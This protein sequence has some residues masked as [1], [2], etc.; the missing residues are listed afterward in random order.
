MIDIVVVLDKSGSMYTPRDDTIGSFNE[1]LETQ[2]QDPDD[3]RMSL[4]MFNDRYIPIYSQKEL[5]DVEELDRFGYA[6]SGSTALLDAVGETITK[7]QDDFNENTIFVIITDGQE[8]SSKEYSVEAVRALVEDSEAKGWE[9]HFLGVGLDDFSDA[10]SI[11]TRST[12]SFDH[13][14]SGVSHMYAATGS[15]VMDYKKDRKD[16]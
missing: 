3:T 14:K 12:Q 5:Q 1:F 16:K 2:K 7:L 9:F 8:N 6:P 15:L 13:S 10:Y 4:V 11:G